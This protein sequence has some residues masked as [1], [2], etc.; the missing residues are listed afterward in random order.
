MIRTLIA[1]DEPI[2]RAILE[3]FVGKYTDIQ[4]I[5]SCSD[6]QTALSVI[7]NQHPD[8]LLLDIQMPELNGLDLASRIAT[9]HYLPS[10]VFITA[11]D[12]YALRAFEVSAIDY[13]LKPFDFERFDKAIQKAKRNLQQPNSSQQ[14]DYLALLKDLLP[15]QYPDYFSVKDGGRIQLVQADSLTHI[16]AE[17]NY[18][19]LHTERTKYLLYE[20]MTHI[21]T[22]LNPKH[23]ARIHRSI[24]VNRRF[25]KEIQSHFNGDYSVVLHNAKVLRMSRNYKRGLL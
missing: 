19:A 1:D 13:L 20:T 10:I 25:V 15:K 23:F 21:E 16:E 5:A 8:L 4:L 9:H 24:I 14:S 17:G 7:E 18:V 12:E 22:Q 3:Q 6:G 11:F 2:A